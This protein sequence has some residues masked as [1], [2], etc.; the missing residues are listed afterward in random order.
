MANV[1]IIDKDSSLSRQMY[2]FVKEMDD[3]NEVRTFESCEEF[4]SIFFPTES[5]AAN[6]DE[7]SAKRLSTIDLI[8]FGIIDNVEQINYWMSEVLKKSIQKKS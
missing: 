3:K 7:I 4:D 2:N 1:V 5:S 8:I 6:A